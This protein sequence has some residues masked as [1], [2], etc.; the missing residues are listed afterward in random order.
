MMS[1]HVW[2]TGANGYIGEA[3]T[4]QLLEDDF[5][6][7]AL[8]RDWKSPPASDLLRVHPFLLPDQIPDDFINDDSSWLV[9]LAYNTQFRSREESYRTNVEGTLRLAKLW[10]KKARGIFVFVSSMSAHEQATSLYGKTKFLVEKELAQ[11]LPPHRLL[12]LRP[13]FVLGDGGLSKR[14]LESISKLRIVPLFDGGRQAIQVV[15]LKDLV[16]M[17]AR[18]IEQNLNGELNLGSA[19]AMPIKDF[20]RMYSS[21]AGVRA[22]MIPVPF[23]SVFQLALE[24]IEKIGFHFPVTSENI[25]GV[26]SLRYFDV[27]KS[28]QLLNFPSDYS[29]EL[30]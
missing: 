16:Q 30:R 9:H 18:S 14:L 19:R 11:I 4:R 2:I 8:V 15:D 3:L 21:K 22:M 12:I 1:K 28:L 27:E 13:G 26:R 23:S 29:A 5:T 6:V 17:L 20:Y 25:K 24:A 10:A 7:S